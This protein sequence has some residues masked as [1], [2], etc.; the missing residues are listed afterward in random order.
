M[1]KI[2]YL[3]GYMRTVE[4]VNLVNCEDC[5]N[6]V[7]RRAL[8]CP[9]CGSPI[10][11][12]AF[13]KE[14][15]DLEEK[16]PVKELAIVT[17]KKYVK[18]EPVKSDFRKVL[19]WLPAV[20][21]GIFLIF[22]MVILSVTSVSV[23]LALIAITLLLPPAQE[24]IIEYFKISKYILYAIS[25]VLILFFMVA[26]TPEPSPEVVA[27]REAER[28][29]QKEAESVSTDTSKAMLVTQCELVIKPQLKN[30]KSMNVDF[31]ATRRYS[32]NKGFNLEMG[33]YAE[34]SFGA[35]MM[36]KALC[37]FDELGNLT[38]IT[39]LE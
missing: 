20:I 12:Q 11:E 26:S 8:A 9:N 37:E 34:N 32:T 13:N 24:E 3:E 5:G 30:P 27:K 21:V 6:S 7:S 31:S 36:N 4:M 33:Y 1:L 23:L 2:R 10:Q 16:E 18:P 29:N 17:L 28:A 19:T 25:G 14:Q 35:N 15:E 39:F 38:N 22:I